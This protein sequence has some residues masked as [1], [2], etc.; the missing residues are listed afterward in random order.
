MRY[1][2]QEP[3]QGEWR[4]DCIDECYDAEDEYGHYIH[5]CVMD[6][7]LAIRLDHPETVPQP[8]TPPGRVREI[9][10]RYQQ[11]MA[12]SKEYPLECG[13]SC[14]SDGV[15]EVHLTGCVPW[16]RKELSGPPRIYT[17]EDCNIDIVP[18]GDEDQYEAGYAESEEGAYDEDA[19]A[20]EQD[21]DLESKQSNAQAPEV[22]QRPA[23]QQS[24]GTE[25][26]A[27]AADGL[28]RPASSGARK[29]KRKSGDLEISQDGEESPRHRMRTRSSAKREAE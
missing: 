12:R 10:T 6:R 26:Q 2:I 25:D 11:M 4:T 22:D 29:G 8:G 28:S 13:H 5:H 23:H 24:T 16:I 15:K 3:G 20:S 27:P 7:E 17:E 21:D 1:I 14:Y 19:S 9:H 18:Y